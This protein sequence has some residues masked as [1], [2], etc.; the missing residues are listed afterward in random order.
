MAKKKCMICV[1]MDDRTAHYRAQSIGHHDHNYDIH[2]CESCALQ[3]NDIMRSANG[4][5]WNSKLDKLSAQKILEELLASFEYRSDSEM[6]SLKDL[7]KVVAASFVI[8][9]KKRR[10]DIPDQILL[11]QKQLDSLG[12]V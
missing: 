8:K 11:L 1:P 5:D 2:I 10:V 3:F 6:I 4:F 9:I 12:K 7:L